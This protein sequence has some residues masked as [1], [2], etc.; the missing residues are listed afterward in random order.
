MPDRDPRCVLATP[1]ARVA[2][3]IAAW[4][5]HREFPAEPVTA[6][7]EFQVWVANAEHASPAKELLDEQRDAIQAQRER[8]ERRAARTG[9]VSAECEE[10]GKAS[11]WPAAAMG[12]TQTCPHCGRYMDVP[13]P[14]EDWD[15]VDFGAEEGEDT[16]PSE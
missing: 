6:E 13:D 8:D 12:S 11:D 1:D 9:T 10:C 3:A 14:D 4:L 5:T 7:G 16:P 2:E 15:D